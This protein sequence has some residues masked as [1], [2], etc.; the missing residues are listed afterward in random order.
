[1]ERWPPNLLVESKWNS[2]VHFHSVNQ[3]FSLP[4][5]LH[6]FPPP[7]SLLPPSLPHI[8]NLRKDYLDYFS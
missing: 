2:V 4:P 5:L 6:S 1:M 3:S 8:D 7:P